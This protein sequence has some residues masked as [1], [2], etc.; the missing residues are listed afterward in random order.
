MLVRAQRSFRTRQFVFNRAVY[1]DCGVRTT[2]NYVCV[3]VHTQDNVKAREKE[4]RGVKQERKIDLI[5][6]IAFSHFF[7]LLNLHTNRSLSI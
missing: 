4:K 1:Y 2:Y 6:F 3:L 5:I 7:S